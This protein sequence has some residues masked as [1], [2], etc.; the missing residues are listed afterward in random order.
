[1]QSLALDVKVL[2]EDK[3]EVAIGE[4][5]ED[6][7]DMLEAAIKATDDRKEV[8]LTFDE[9]IGAGVVDDDFS[10]DTEDD[11]FGDDAFDDLF[12]AED[13]MFGSDDMFEDDDE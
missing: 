4:M 3:E 13:D 2:S 9:E 11:V 10:F 8:A 12:D 7:Q 6:E 1:L 5:I